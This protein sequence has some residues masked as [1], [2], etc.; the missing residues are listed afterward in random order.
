MA[1]ESDLRT[2]TQPEKGKGDGIRSLVLITND[3]SRNDR[4]QANETQQ[5]GRRRSRTP[6]LQ[7]DNF[8]RRDNRDNFNRD[9]RSTQ[10]NETRYGPNNRNGQ[11]GNGRN[12]LRR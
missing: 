10:Q 4:F 12:N 2:R 9:T 7:R 6:H 3:R 1:T 5:Q 11:K 8:T